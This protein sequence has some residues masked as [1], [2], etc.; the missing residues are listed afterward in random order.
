MYVVSIDAVEISPEAVDRFERKVWLARCNQDREINAQYLENRFI[1]MDDA[2]FLYLFHCLD[3][4]D[5][6]LSPV[7]PGEWLPRYVA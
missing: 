3:G 6:V 5:R 4:C 2:G 1:L 7:L